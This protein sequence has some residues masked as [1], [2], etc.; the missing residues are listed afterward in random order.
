[1]RGVT[2]RL[3]I[4][5]MLVSLFA[6]MASLENALNGEKIGIN[7]GGRVDAVDFTIVAIDVGNSSVPAQTWTQPDTSTTDY[8]LRNV[9]YS[10]SVTF[11]QAGNGIQFYDAYGTLEVVHP[12]GFVVALWGFNLTMTG[13]QQTQVNVRWTPEA[14]H[15]SVD[16]NG[17]LSGGMI[18]RATID[19]GV[20]DSNEANDE[21]EE[22]V[23]VALWRDKLE[24]SILATNYLQF[25]PVAYSS[26]S[27]TELYL[28][29]TDWQRENSSAAAAGNYHMRVSDPGSQY[30]STT[31]EM[32]RWGWFIPNGGNCDDPGHG[33]GFGTMDQDI[34]TYYGVP[35]CLA[36]VNDY[37]YLSIQWVTNAWG[38]M[39]LGDEMALEAV[40]G[41]SQIA[42][43]NLTEQNLMASPGAWK[44]V[45]W[46]MT[47]IHNDQSYYISF[48]KIAD[49]SD[50]SEGIHVDDFALFA[51]EKVWQYTVS[52]DCDDPSPNAY[53][54]IPADPNP[55]S[56]YCQL[57]NN[58]Y[59]TAQISIHTEVSNSTWM[60]TYPLRI[61]SSNTLDH[62]NFVTQYPLPGGATTEFWINLSVP[63]GANVESLNW[64]VELTDATSGEQ[65]HWML[66]P[67]TVDAS[68]SVRI[69]QLNPAYPALTLSPGETGDVAMFVKN[70]GN[71][72]ANWNLGSFFSDAIWGG[73]NLEWLEDWDED[74]NLSTT[75]QV[76]LAKGAEKT[77]IARFSAPAEVPPGEVE[78]SLV[79]SGVPPASAQS[80]E[81]IY[82]E[83]PGTS[84]VSVEAGESEITAQANGYIRTVEMIVKNNGNSPES[85]DISVN[86]DWHIGAYLTSQIT[87][88]IDP[89]G[90]E[91][92]VMVVLP[93]PQGLLPSFYT[94]SITATSPNNQFIS[95]TGSFTL[96]V[97]IT[98]IVEVVGDD[99]TDQSFGAGGVNDRTLNF[100][101]FNHG[102]KD[103]FFEVS[104]TMDDGVIASI[105]NG[106]VDDDNT[107]WIPAGTST[108]VTLSYRFAEGTQGMKTLSLTA[109]SNQ[110]QAEGQS[111]QAEG[112]VNFQV[113]SVGWI[114]L[115]PSAP[116]SISDSGTY[117][118][119]VSVRNR[120]PSQ[121]Q[122]IRMS[123]DE[124][125]AVYY[126]DRVRVSTSDQEFLLAPDELRVVHIEVW[127]TDTNLANLIEDEMTF[128]IT[129]TAEAD[130]DVATLT[131]PLLVNHKALSSGANDGDD[132]NFA[133][134][135]KSVVLW[136]IGILVVIILLAALVMVLRS[137]EVEDE[138]S[139]LSGYESTLDSEYGSLPPAPTLP[140]APT[141]PSTDLDAN[142]MYGGSQALFEQPVMETPPAP[143][144][145]LPEGLPPA[146]LPPTAAAPAA[147]PEPPAPEPPA[148]APAASPE[149]PAPEPAAAA[150]ESAD[151]PTGGPPLPEDGLPEGW[152]TEQWKHYG[153]EYLSR[154]QG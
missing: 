29:G 58:G 127:V 140:D 141:L 122:R 130:D 61:D 108:N 21:Y 60:N 47:D 48:T 3:L 12:I 22:A 17:L 25:V 30:A 57:T 40:R 82:I 151:S 13:G 69:D 26:R 1:M 63:D 50:A 8:L 114:V 142:S 41:F 131:I 54:V 45:V 33:M 145:A 84:S 126:L 134:M 2:A 86:A 94:I 87:E 24:G 68:Y 52:L 111:V 147:P 67:V 101:V 38:T 136:G 72:F 110:A 6:P 135:V 117:L 55:P 20:L 18:L 14:A 125:D 81:R 75:N 11:M 96:E 133:A 98:Y 88:Q 4:A 43:F 103:D 7:T 97:P 124:G 76:S 56:L 53:V 132:S 34:Q 16:P 119:N 150:D 80:V 118:M 15:S 91:A 121:Q 23:P 144:A 28:G 148:P 79:A 66:L 120:H 106:L 116:L 109:V 59:R 73:S 90:G 10:V 100:E 92:V 49:D 99:M 37:E 143:T 129:L 154:K 19:G 112:E 105:S 113:G 102:N 146:G 62:D 153:E 93:M 31:E 139:T 104:L 44:Q 70:T 65:K 138:I 123:V 78:V 137:T 85:F 42:A 9:Q 115:D 107:A 39:G 36:Q 77:V 32:L 71:Q 95:G 149:P 64:T 51:I 46:D 152:S 83:I 35:F 128:N 74:G 89:F 5:I 27:P